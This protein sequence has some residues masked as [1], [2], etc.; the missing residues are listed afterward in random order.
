[1]K[2]IL[3]SFLWLAFLDI[4]FAICGYIPIMQYYS[5]N[6]STYTHSFLSTLFSF[7]CYVFV[8]IVI[9]VG[10]YRVYNIKS[11]LTI[12]LFLQPVKL[13]FDIFSSFF[14][15]NSM[16]VGIIDIYIMLIAVCVIKICML[17]KK[18]EIKAVFS[19]A[20]LV[21]G[22]FVIIICIIANF[23][24]TLWYQYNLSISAMKYGGMH[25][26]S[27]NDFPNFSFYHTT[28]YILV[29][30][31]TN[32]A[33]ILYI[34]LVFQKLLFNS[35]AITI[36]AL[37]F[38]N[39]MLVVLIISIYFLSL[40]LVPNYTNCS[41]LVDKYIQQNSRAEEL[42]LYAHIKSVKIQKGNSELY[43]WIFYSHNYIDVYNGDKLV[44]S[45]STN[46]YYVDKVIEV[47][48]GYTVNIGDEITMHC[49]DGEWKY[50]E[51]FE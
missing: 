21:L 38:K 9:A 40:L 8:Y 41:F 45:Y 36:K 2:K 29:Q 28:I 22:C 23:I 34:S 25:L 35:Q 32:C 47:V 39:I 16:S 14:L 37:I 4:T 15:T 1:M 18:S 27:E 48:D 43:N 3:Y 17:G 46:T 42:D 5:L 31:I 6:I 19:R 7:F 30:F 11:I 50:T 24:P 20:K 13:I 33:L 10:I 44:Y 12:F 26:I 51:Q 49:E